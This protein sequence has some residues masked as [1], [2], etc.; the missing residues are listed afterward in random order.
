[1]I[2]PL[3]QFTQEWLDHPK[4]TFSCS[5]VSCTPQ[6][7]S[8]SSSEPVDS[9]L[10]LWFLPRPLAL[11]VV[12]ITFFPP[13]T[14]EH[15][16][17][18]ALSSLSYLHRVYKPGTSL[19]TIPLKLAFLAT[20]TSCSR[21]CERFHKATSQISAPYYVGEVFPTPCSLPVLFTS[22]F[23]FFPLTNCSPL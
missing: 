5:G 8:F 1:V 23:F 14:P 16:L 20:T 3:S 18:F 7:P 6:A 22:V 11:I 21:V 19:V 12:M 2:L 4:A 9:R 15:V 13:P 10:P 17:F